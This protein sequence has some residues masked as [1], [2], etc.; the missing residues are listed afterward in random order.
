MTYA[1]N[2]VGKEIIQVQK[3][4]TNAQKDQ[5][6]ISAQIQSKAVTLALTVNL[7]AFT[8]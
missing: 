2:P 8:V 4:S 1:I 7:T 6:L 3:W 5:K